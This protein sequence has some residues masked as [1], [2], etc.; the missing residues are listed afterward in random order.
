MT[1]LKKYFFYRLGKGIPALLIGTALGLLMA[2]T[3][4]LQ[5]TT[6]RSGPDALI[7]QGM[8]LIF[9]LLPTVYTVR[10]FLPLRQERTR[11]LL[12]SV[13]SEH[14]AFV[15]H[16]LSALLQSFI[17]LTAVF[18]AFSVLIDIPLRIHRF[19]P[20]LFC[21]YAMWTFVLC[22]LTAVGFMIGKKLPVSLILALLL[23][24]VAD[25]G[26]TRRQP[27]P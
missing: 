12:L 7:F 1:T 24:C 26:T 22:A 14:R 21:L 19:Y 13:I 20:I 2:L 15:C 5:S 4:F 8:S 25:A 10:E 17:T 6:S 27:I 9:Y 11:D 18:G 3:G 16:F 23:P